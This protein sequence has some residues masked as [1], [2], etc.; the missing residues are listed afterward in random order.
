[1]KSEPRPRLPGRLPCRPHQTWTCTAAD[2]R[3]GV[4]EGAGAGQMAAESA[5]QRAQTR[6]AGGLAL[7]SHVGGSK[8]KQTLVQSG[9]CSRANTSGKG[10]CRPPGAPLVGVGVGVGVGAGTTGS[11]VLST[12]SCS[13]APGATG[14]G[15]GSLSACRPQAAFRAALQGA[16]EKEAPVRRHGRPW[17]ARAQLLAGRDQRWWRQCMPLQ[18]LGG[19][20][21]TDAD[22]QALAV[23][24]QWRGP[25]RTASSVSQRH[26]G[27]S[28]WQQS[29]GGCAGPCSA[30]PTAAQACTAP[31]EQ[32]RSRPSGRGP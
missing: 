24:L 6:R 18:L 27:R 4:P 30:I 3:E 28:Q 31:C 5:A 26:G 19:S 21:A 11:G 15:M 1:M 12:G 7:G 20:G 17:A 2:S 13:S 29:T 9:N 8:T 22:F 23:H 25:Q 16:G 10:R 14:S 32:F